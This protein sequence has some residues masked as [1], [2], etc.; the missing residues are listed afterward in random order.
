MNF[1]NPSFHKKISS[2]ARQTYFRFS[3]L[4]ID[5]FNFEQFYA[6]A[7]SHSNGLQERLLHGKPGPVMNKCLGMPAAIRD[8]PVGEDAE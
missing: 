8:F 6:S 4:L 1:F 3:T 7:E 5:D 2:A